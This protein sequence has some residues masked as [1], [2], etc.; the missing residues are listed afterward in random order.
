MTE[1]EQRIEAIKIT[2]EAMTK[3]YTAVAVTDKAGADK[4]AD[5]IVK[6]AERLMAFIGRPDNPQSTGG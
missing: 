1:A 2:L 3:F 6:G 4:L 5:E